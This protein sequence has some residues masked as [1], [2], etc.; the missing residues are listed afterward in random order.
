MIL[1]GNEIEKEV[2][3]SKITIVPF[4]KVQVNPNSYNY[5]LGSKLIDLSAKNVKEIIIPK[6]GFVLKPNQIYL[7]STYEVLGSNKYAMS[8]IGRSSLGRLGLFL[9]ISAN[10]GHTGSE[11]S[12]TLELVCVKPIRIYP[13]MIIG[14]ISFWDNKGQI[15]PYKKRYSDHNSPKQSRIRG[16]A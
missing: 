8:L 1:T 15:T 13:R 9:Q 14:Q 3:R 16:V 6:N 10:L 4:N 12:W 2:K 7:A 11:H 5:R